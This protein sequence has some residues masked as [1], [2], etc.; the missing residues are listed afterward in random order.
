MC[1]LH[2]GRAWFPVLS[3]SHAWSHEMRG[4]LGQR[5]I[6]VVICP[7][8]VNRTFVSAS[9]FL[10]FL[11]GPGS[12]FSTTFLFATAFNWVVHPFISGVMALFYHP[13]TTFRCFDS[14]LPNNALSRQCCSALCLCPQPDT[15]SLRPYT[16]F[17]VHLRN[18]FH[19]VFSRLY[20]DSS[21]ELRI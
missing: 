1:Y 2:L 16:S 11:S 10:L 15:D 20:P 5:D 3:Y 13:Y 8:R 18:V 21:M 12:L 7:T 17:P 14:K 4:L 6:P 19:L 9:T